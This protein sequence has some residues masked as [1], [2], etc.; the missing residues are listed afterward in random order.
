MILPLED[1]LCNTLIKYVGCWLTLKGNDFLAFANTVHKSTFNS[2]STTESETAFSAAL[3]RD[4][5]SGREFL[6]VSVIFSTSARDTHAQT[7]A[8]VAARLA[9]ETISAKSCASLPL[10]PPVLHELCRRPDRRAERQGEREDS[11]SV[12]KHKIVRPLTVM[13][14]VPEPVTVLEALHPPL[15]SFQITSSPPPGWAR[16]YQTRRQTTQLSWL[17]AGFCHIYTLNWTVLERRR[18]L[19]VLEVLFFHFCLCEKRIFFLFPLSLCVCLSPS[20]SLSVCV[21]VALLSC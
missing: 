2:P 19:Q 1:Y 13:A 15:L 18:K 6:F 8:I 7:T 11:L 3:G 4:N 9:Q 21:V 10:L 17:L 16:R 12:N 5:T 14:P 20:V